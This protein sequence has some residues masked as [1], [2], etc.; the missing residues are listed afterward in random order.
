MES[1]SFE[2]MKLINLFIIL[3]IFCTPVFSQNNSYN[4]PEPEIIFRDTVEMLAF[5]SATHSLSTT[6]KTVNFRI[7]KHFKNIGQSPVIISQAFTSDP[8]FICE[9][10]REPMIQGKVYAFKVCFTFTSSSVD[11][12]WK[13]TMGFILSD[14]KRIDLHFE[15]D[16]KAW[17]GE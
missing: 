9:Y 3:L 13:K 16:V 7:V 2:R 8:H 1:V 11:Y 6:N 12:H 15:G 5:D 10:P 4:I 14:E 17:K